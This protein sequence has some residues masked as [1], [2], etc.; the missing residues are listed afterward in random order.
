MLSTL[1]GSSWLLDD[2]VD[3]GKYEEGVENPRV[4]DKADDLGEDMTYGIHPPILRLS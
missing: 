1:F 4:G 2:E 3:E